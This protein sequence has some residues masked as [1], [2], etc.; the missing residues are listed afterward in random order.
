MRY[1]I[2]GFQKCTKLKFQKKYSTKNIYLKKDPLRI[3]FFGTDEFSA[4]SLLSLIS[5]S[6]SNKTVLEK[7]GVVTLPDSKIGRGH[8]TLYKTPVKLLAVEHNLKVY[9]MKKENIWETTGILHDCAKIFNLVV[10]V[11]FGHL[12]PSILLKSMEYGGIN[13]HPSLLP[14]YKGPAPLHHTLLNKDKYTGVT[15]QTLHPYKFDEGKII[16][17]SE[18][19]KVTEQETLQTL[20]ETLSKIAAELLIQTLL[21]QEYLN[22]NTNLQ[23]IYEPSYARK[24]TKEDE[25][26]KWNLWS[27]N[28]IELRNRVFGKLRSKFKS[29]N[30]IVILSDIEIV[31]D[32][33]EK[34]YGYSGLYTYSKNGLYVRCVDGRNIKIGKIKIEGKNWVNG[35][36]WAMTHLD[37]KNGY[38]V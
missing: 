7:I 30:K 28:E 16:S 25:I 14:R 23:N 38:F 26:I 1:I 19:Y 34:I 9:E 3:L 11:S 13:V 4:F 10:S 8:K 22:V 18:L 27:S 20:S 36:E 32:T 5:L 37:E 2:F 24:L 35:K 29:S 15:I 12:I 21:K 31:N 6:Q 17:V 33:E